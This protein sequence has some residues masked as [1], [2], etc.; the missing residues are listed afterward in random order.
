MSSQENQTQFSQVQPLYEQPVNLPVDPQVQAVAKKRKKILLMVSATFAIFLSLIWMASVLLPRP[1]RSGQS[2]PVVLPTPTPV[3]DT[4]LRGRIESAQ[5][6][7]RYIGQTE[8][9]LPLPQVDWNI[10]LED[11]KE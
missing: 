4:S 9:Q 2:T 8:Y 1:D 3:P 7:L 5:T 11:K 6:E 10:R